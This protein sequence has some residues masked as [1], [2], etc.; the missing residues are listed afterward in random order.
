VAKEVLRFLREHG[1]SMT[2]FAA[3][4]VRLQRNTIS[5]YLVTSVTGLCEI[6][7]FGRIFRSLGVIFSKKSLKIHLHKLQ[8]L[9]AFCL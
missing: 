9:A 2:D 4:V 6:S 1:I 8:I 3:K 5:S 7:P